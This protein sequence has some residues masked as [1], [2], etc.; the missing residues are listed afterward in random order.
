MPRLSQQLHVSVVSEVG[1][2]R[3]VLSTHS[4]DW[5][6]ALEN[7]SKSSPQDCTGLHVAEEYVY[8]RDMQQ[9]ASLSSI[10]HQL[11]T[12]HLGACAVLLTMLSLA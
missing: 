5:G 11:V 9:H 12:A 7:Q 6:R 2:V 4:L 1:Q 3:G 10:P 8:H